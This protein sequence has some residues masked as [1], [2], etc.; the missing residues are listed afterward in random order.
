M[1]LAHGLSIDSLAELSQGNT[2]LASWYAPGFSDELGDRLLMFD[3]SSAPSLELLRF[4]HALTATPGFEVALRRRVE[5]LRHFRHP[6]FTKVRSVEYLGPGD[7]LALLSNHT[8]GKR[9]SDVLQDVRGPVFATALIQQLTPALASLQEYGEGG[10]HGALAPSRI[11]VTPDG[12][13]LIVE[14][15]L[16]PALE[17]LQL[18]ADRLRTELGIA[19]PPVGT[20]HYRL[21]SRTDYFQLGLIALSLLVGRRLGSNESQ[22]EIA[23]LLEECA[24]TAHRD[25]P[26]LFGPLRI[27]LERALQLNDQVFESGE[28][29][30]DALLDLAVA[31]A[32]RHALPAQPIPEPHARSAP[33]V[34]P[35]PIPALPEPSALVIDVPP[36]VPAALAE[37]DPAKAWAAASAHVSEVASEP[38]P[39]ELVLPSEAVEPRLEAALSQPVKP[40]PEPAY[41]LASLQSAP[42]ERDQHVST[43][44]T[45][46]IPNQEAPAPRIP[47]EDPPGPLVSVTPHVDQDPSTSWTPPVAKDEEPALIHEA[48]SS[49]SGKSMSVEVEPGEPELA[50]SFATTKLTEEP[51]PAPPRP[52]ARHPLTKTRGREAVMRAA[53]Y[54]LAMCALGE[55]F[56]IA[57]LLLSRRPAAPAAVFLETAAPGADVLVDGQP[58][59][60]TPLQL[61]IGAGATRSIRVVDSRPA[62]IEGNP[63]AVSGRATPPRPD[64]GTAG[65]APAAPTPRSG[66]IRLLSPIDV[67][68]FEG[69]RRLG[70]SATGIVSVAAGRHEID[71]VNSRLGYRDRQ[72]V[73]VR[74]GQ[75]V[76]VNVSPPN[77]RLSINAVPWAEVWIGG[78][79]V[80]ETPLGNLSVP[81]GDHE[82]VFRH[83]QLGE[84]RQTATVR[85]DGVTRV[86]A[87]LQR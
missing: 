58:A 33:D 72:I 64:V 42:R 86:S 39:V 26:G 15:V 24:R 78:K 66:G 74:G 43:F 80:G 16:G 22:E 61:D 79:L 7:G 83:P 32:A 9:L 12:R 34:A 68:V 49:E 57:G 1:K 45:P 55:G 75:V 50:P 82:I 81:L 76:P 28:D 67:E 18:S 21:D 20:A 51:I 35:I 6:S 11:V 47:H 54:A 38:L 52:Q 8:P 2:A 53:V 36:D 4:K 65:S 60:V 3:N 71:L 59:G 17:R 19:L 14:H 37:P 44:S 85:L 5:R 84:Q 10:G 41:E 63:Q 46:P 29:A 25:S 56:V 27:W 31:G 23:R 69:D 13:L 77:G 70:S 73:Y 87:V 40:E 62:G 30:E 48:L